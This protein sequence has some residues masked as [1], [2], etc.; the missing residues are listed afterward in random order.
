[1]A[2]LSLALPL[3]PHK[4]N[5][6]P[7]SPDRFAFLHDLPSPPWT[8][9]PRRPFPSAPREGID[10]PTSLDKVPLTKTLHPTASPSDVLFMA[11][12]LPMNVAPGSFPAASFLRVPFVRRD[13]TD[14]TVPIIVVSTERLPAGKKEC[15]VWRVTE[16]SDG[17]F[18]PSCRTWGSDPDGSTTDDQMLELWSVKLTRAGDVC[19]AWHVEAH[20]GYVEPICGR[21][22]PE[23]VL[24][25]TPSP[26]M[27]PKS[28]FSGPL[29]FGH[30]PAVPSS[31]LIPREVQDTDN[32]L[33]NPSQFLSGYILPKLC[34]NDPCSPHCSHR[35]PGL[36]CT[37][38]A[39]GPE[40]LAGTG[41]LSAREDKPETV[42][43]PAANVGPVG[44]PSVAPLD[45]LV[46]EVKD[47]GEKLLTEGKE[48]GKKLVADGEKLGE[49]LV[50]EGK[51]VGI[52]L[53]VVE[54]E[55]VREA[56]DMFATGR[57]EVAQL[58]DSPRSSDTL[59]A[60]VTISHPSPA[61]GLRHQKRLRY[62]LVML[63]ESS[64]FAGR[65]LYKARILR[66][67]SP[68]LSIMAPY[69]TVI[70]AIPNPVCTDEDRHD[71][72]V[73]SLARSLLAIFRKI[74]LNRREHFI[75]SIAKNDLRLWPDRPARLQ[76]PLKHNRVVLVAPY[77][78]A[79]IDSYP[80]P[81]LQPRG[82]AF[83]SVVWLV[84]VHVLADDLESG[85]AGLSDAE[86]EE[87]AGLL[88]CLGAE[89][90]RGVGVL[91]GEAA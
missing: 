29:H 69:Y 14:T 53:M 47:G 91:G 89:V 44:L 45:Q 40:Q 65:H 9:S 80:L 13:D 3:A 25:F 15:K 74:P 76:N 73:A 12:D 78:E 62:T 42:Y 82:K 1:M 58:L 8:F 36:I 77:T 67:L 79:D 72:H 85:V 75:R 87:L 84:G 66:Y 22:K 10:F 70:I 55:V 7:S 56:K 61:R 83:D 18:S 63:Q 37:S 81:A 34:K 49:K 26:S 6:P 60:H 41:E 50:A 86:G 39:G 43:D 28:W 52:E 30:G 46:D 16:S 19:T 54:K 51:E 32:I 31:G 11:P 88:A 35:T 4:D 64:D 90:L 48:A 24:P 23:A 5:G 68:T 27:D 33:M 2:T 38:T 59:D 21:V 20:H 57:E 17:V 71:Q